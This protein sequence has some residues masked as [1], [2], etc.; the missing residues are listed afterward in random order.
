MT[1]LAVGWDKR[2]ERAPAHHCRALPIQSRLRPMPNYRRY[3]V[4]GGTYFFTCVTYGRAPILTTPLGRS[5]LRRALRHVQH[6][7]PFEIVAVVLLPEHLHTVWTL[8]AGD[9]RYPM[10]WMRI[11]EEY[12][13]KWLEGGGAELA[14]TPSRTR[15]RQ[16]GVWQKRYWEHFV[17]HEADLH[18]CVDYVHWNPRKHRH[19]ARVCDWRWSSFHRFVTAGDYDLEWGGTDPTPGWDAP[20]WGEI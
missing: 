13:E 5:C 4:P 19:V 12:T 2:A 18:R 1:V 20:E 11:K 16:R 14:Q 7:H 9:D 15:H 6:E 3:Y 10:R 17:A 8:P